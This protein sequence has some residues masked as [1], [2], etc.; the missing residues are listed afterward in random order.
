MACACRGS[1]QQFGLS[2]ACG[3]PCGYGSARGIERVRITR[4]LRLPLDTLGELRGVIYRRHGL[5]GEPPK[6]YV[7]FFKR[8][9]LLTADPTG[10]RLF[11]IGGQYRVTR[12]GIEG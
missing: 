4:V 1:Q 8:A 2:C 10:R 7:H 6:N 5:P 12:R 9:P 11:I 3:S